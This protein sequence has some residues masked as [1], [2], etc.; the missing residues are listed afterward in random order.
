[1]IRYSIK[2]Q[3]ITSIT[4]QVVSNTSASLAGVYVKYGEKD[5][6]SPAQPEQV[7]APDRSHHESEGNRSS[8]GGIV[9]KRTTA[10]YRAG[11]SHRHPLPDAEID[12]EEVSWRSLCEITAADAGTAAPV[13][14]THVDF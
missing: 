5:F 10:P 8:D 12:G 2:V 11:P 6:G 1:V 4:T 9:S 13:I 3:T 7:A 14:G